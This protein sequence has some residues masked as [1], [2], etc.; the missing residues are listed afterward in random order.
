MRLR[1]AIVVAAAGA[2]L[3]G[4]G[5]LLGLVT[6]A[7]PAAFLSWPLLLALALL[8]PA[9]AFAFARLGRLGTAAAVLVGPAA[10]APGRL[11]LDLQFAVDA[12]LATRPELLRV[13][14]LDAFAPAI[15]VWLLVA[16]HVTAIVAGVLAV[17]GLDHGDEGTGSHRQGL[18]TLVLCA[19]VIAAVGVLMAPFASDDPYL[20]SN[21][22]LDAPP[23]VLIGSVLLAI[24]V[25]S[26][27]G[28]LAGSTDPDFAR[29][30]LLGVAAAL[31]GVVVPPLASAVVL[32]EIQF[33]WGPV[34]GLVAVVALAVLAMPAGR[35]ESTEPA[36]DLRLPALTRLIT[37]SAVFAL[38]AGALAVLAAAVPQVEMPRG[39]RDPSPYPARMLWPAGFLLVAL[40][41][42]LLLPRAARWLRPM[43]PVVWVVIPFAAAGVLDAVFT[44]VQ[45]ADAH[46][47]LGAWTAGSAV[48]VAA[49]AA[50]IAAI[51]GAVERDD[52]DLTEIA[53]HRLVLFP[54]LVALLLGAGAFSVPVVTA[55]D[56][57]APGVFTAFGTTSWGLVVALAA[58]VGAAVLAPMCR[59]ARAAAL[60]CGAAL[61]VAVRVLEYPLTA[62]R[63][64]ESTPGLGLWFGAACV[65][66][67]LGTAL[68]AARAPRDRH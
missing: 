13:E 7:S 41:V 36:E 11:V 20:L 38:V 30:G 57:T 65:L 37:L 34:L 29:G 10:L 23:V 42:G 52:V 54:S 17:R 50:I 12:G 60:L 44:A 9:L 49:L 1:V 32:D 63:L 40:G 45:A 43:L 6:P 64:P 39:L 56:Y 21:P 59:P 15:G 61:V 48:L 27:A 18:L 53:M 47:G 66:V 5:P 16:G 3:V 8:A 4:L 55:P 68:A 62:E 19:G 31:A 22:A 28:F 14:S 51:A 25:P 46:A 35:A 2:L 33:D 67:L 58:V 24:G 26:A